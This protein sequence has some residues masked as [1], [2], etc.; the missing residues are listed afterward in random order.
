MEKQNGRYKPSRIYLKKASD[1]YIALLN[2][3]ST[4]LRHSKSLV[5]LFMNRKLR[6]R[7]PAISEKYTFCQ[8]NDKK[9]KSTDAKIK[10]RQKV[11]F[12]KRH[13]AKECSSFVEE[14]PVW[15]NTSKTSQ[16]NIVK[17]LSPRSVLVKME[18]GLLRRNKSHL[19]RRNDQTKFS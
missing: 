3:L 15:V 18:S 16:G 4:P 9:Y 2:S 11:D 1:P 7:I 17:S 19:R 6:T 5:E 12:D 13:R 8:Y 10:E 14:Q